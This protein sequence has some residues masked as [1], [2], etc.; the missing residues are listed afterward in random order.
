MDDPQPVQDLGGL[1]DQLEYVHNGA[2]K[3]RNGQKNK[4]FQDW[5]D[6]QREAEGLPM[7]K[8]NPKRPNLLLGRYL[9]NKRETNGEEYEPSSLAGTFSMR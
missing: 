7:A 8:I 2:A 6:R 5:L 4:A 9:L 1:Q 3:H